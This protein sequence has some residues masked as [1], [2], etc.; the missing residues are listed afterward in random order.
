M[1]EF[2]SV[3]N[4]GGDGEFKYHI[5]V[6]Y[7]EEAELYDVKFTSTYS[8]SKETN[9]HQTK[10]QLFLNSEQYNNLLNVLNTNK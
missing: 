4:H 9:H 5:F 2:L 1:S 3:K 8:A 6:N 10:L 7:L